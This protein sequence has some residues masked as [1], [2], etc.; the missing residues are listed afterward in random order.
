M[1]ENEEEKE[2]YDKKRLEIQEKMKNIV[3]MNRIQVS[4]NELVLHKVNW[5]NICCGLSEYDILYEQKCLKEINKLGIT[6]KRSEIMKTMDK[7][8][9]NESV[10][11]ALHNAI[12]TR[13]LKCCNKHQTFFDKILNKISYPSIEE[14]DNRING[15][16][17]YLY[18]EYLY[19]LNMDVNI[20]KME[21]LILLI[22]CEVRQHLLSRYISLEI[23]RK[24]KN[25]IKEVNAILHKL[26]KM[27]KKIILEH[28]ENERKIQAKENAESG[29]GDKGDKRDE[30]PV[31]NEMDE[32]DYKKMIELKKG[33]ENEIMNNPNLDK[34]INQD[35]R[36]KVEEDIKNLEKG[37]EEN[38]GDEE[39]KNNIYD[40]SIF[41]L[42]DDEK[43]ALS[44]HKGGGVYNKS[45]VKAK[46][47]NI[48]ETRLVFLDQIQII[49]ECY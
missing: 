16:L 36:R 14:C 10:K 49:D 33:D 42:N 38:S 15:A 22:F 11:D 7:V 46:C 21:L 34:L 27:D 32:I 8:M 18:D 43:V 47:K 40:N 26:Y 19:I 4:R 2:L 5:F 1:L 25:N 20:S 48:D 23:M 44:K 39:D 29:D 17:L 30:R 9:S 45:T 24:K 13:L 3:D 31:I 37:A 12:K 41:K 35:I 28:E 6:I